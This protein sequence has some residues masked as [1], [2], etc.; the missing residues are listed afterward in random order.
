MN[1]IFILFIFLCSLKSIA[2]NNSQKNPENQLGVWYMY[3]GSHQVSNKFSL[4]TMAHFRFFEIGD[5][6]QQFIGRFGGNYKINNNISATLGYAFL[7]TDATFKAK[8]GDTNEHRIYEDFNVKHKINTLAFS[9]R[10]RAEQRFFNTKT[11]HLLRYQIALNYPLNNKWDTF[12][13]NETFF[14]F[15]G[16]PYNQNWLGAGFKY[17]ISKAIKLKL[18]YQNI[19]TN[20]DANFNRILL[21]LVI[22]TNHQKK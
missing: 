6:I 8:N 14:D 1:K 15:N 9:H 2:Q 21:G 12:I 17:K 11:D 3:N 18:G 20:Q 7:N 22:N 13:Y 16:E 19:V 4:K 10:F 5:D